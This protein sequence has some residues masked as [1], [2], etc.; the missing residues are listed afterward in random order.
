VPVVGP[1]Q[2]WFVRR[3]A[4][5]SGM[6]VSGIGVGTFTA[7]LIATALMTEWSWRTTYQAMG[8][9]C[10]A[11]GAVAT[12]FIVASPEAK[13]QR[14]DGAAPT[15]ANT[16]PADATPAASPAGGG[17]P[18][19]PGL[20]LKEAIRTRPFW[21]LY[22]ANFVLAFPIFVP[23]VHLVP[24]ASDRGYSDVQA[25][26]TVGMIGV[27]SIVGR[28]LLG[29]LADRFGRRQSLMGS[30]AILAVMLV[31]WGA[32]EGYWL[33]LAFGLIYGT[34]YGGYVALVPAVA[35]DYVGVRSASG[36]LGLLY[37]PFA[38][39]TLIGTASAGYAYDWLKSYDWPILVSAV[40]TALA[41][42]V[43]CMLQDPEKW[44]SARRAANKPA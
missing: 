15:P 36:V 8:V 41:T 27:G 33:L 9:V 26:W 1:V 38:V 34:A 32:V 12:Y 25:A 43:V 29:G 40:L 28:F 11:L 22:I 5:A 37:T 3:R 17:R 31:F 18:A 35:I 44:R 42:A 4:F 13:G 7:P 6:A 20:R 19:L 10:L 14:A 30:F 23:F 2:R 39:G 21:V 24:Y 16:P